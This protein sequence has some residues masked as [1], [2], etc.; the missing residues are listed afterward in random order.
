MNVILPV[1]L[2]FLLFGGFWWLL[3]RLFSLTFTEKTMIVLILVAILIFPLGLFG[4]AFSA[5]LVV[6]AALIAATSFGKIPADPPFLGIDAPFGRP[7]NTFIS[8]PRI[9]FASPALADEIISIPLQPFNWDFVFDEVECNFTDV[10]KEDPNA[11]FVGGGGF[12]DVKISY[13]GSVIP[14]IP[15]CK[16]Y[17]RQGR[18]KGVRDKFEDRLQELVRKHGTYT[19]WQKYVGQ[20]KQVFPEL[21]N[22]YA[23]ILVDGLGLEEGLFNVTAID[24][25]GDLKKV[26][27][28]RAVEMLER[29]GEG[30]DNQTRIANGNAI[31][32][33]LR[34][35]GDN[36]TT[37]VQAMEID[38]V[39]SDR[40][41]EI[42][43]RTGGG[44]KDKVLGAVVGSEL[45]SGHHGT[46]ASTDED[47]DDDG[48]S[49]SD[50]D[51]DH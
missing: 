47:D 5:L 9:A 14:D 48:S 36:D 23:A 1:I 37:L 29:A 39:D 33:A 25:A 45:R 2:A 38:R 11:E 24:P 28:K 44:A 31:L 15:H 8:K 35:S 42:L 49:S 4:W 20:K 34:A 50:D 13:T 18:E 22:G 12:V 43:L 17:I 26:V 46:T 51:H 19:S 41:R 7:G 27:A 6:L 10:D 30:L 32:A 16:D 3:G 40:A 21:V